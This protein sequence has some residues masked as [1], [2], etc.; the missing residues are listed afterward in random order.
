MKNYCENLMKDHPWKWVRRRSFLPALAALILL[1]ALTATASAEEPQCIQG[2]ADISGREVHNFADSVRR[3]S[4]IRGDFKLTL[5]E[6]VLTG[7]DAVVWISDYGEADENLH[8]ITVYME[9]DRQQPAAVIEPGGIENHDRVML[10]VLD[11]DGA[12]NVPGRESE[13]K[14]EDFPLYKRGVEARKKAAEGVKEPV[15]NEAP[16]LVFAANE[17]GEKSGEEAGG[18]TAETGETTADDATD[19]DE[20]AEPDITPAKT[21]PETSA[22]EI[23]DETA[24][25]PA[26]KG[27]TSVPSTYV[28][29]HADKIT[30]HIEPIPDQKLVPG[31]KERKRRVIVA[32]GN[33]YLSRGDADSDLFLELRSETAVI[34]TEMRKPDEKEEKR[35][36]YSPKFGGGN[37]LGEDK[38][39][40]EKGEVETIVGVYL[41]G[42]VVIA[43][44]ER[45]LRAPEA[46]Y[47]FITDR[48]LVIEPVFRTIQE[49]RNIP[50]YIRAKVGRILSAR[51]MWF[52]DAKVSTSDFYSPSYHIGAKQVYLMD[53]TPYGPDG[54][55]LSKPSWMADMEHTT[56]NIRSVPVLYWPKL[57]DDFTQGNTPLRRVQFGREGDFGWGFETQWH[58][59][60]LMGIPKPEGVNAYLDLDVYEQ[61]VMGGVTVKYARQSRGRQY[62]GYSKLYGV[63]DRRMKDDFG[64][65]RDDIPAPDTRG[66]LLVR[67]KEYL[68]K[69]W[70]LQFEL[71]YIC[72]R[73]FL[74][75]YERDE[76]LAGKEQ[77][78]LIY[79]M[80]QRDNWAFTTLL[81]YKTN[82]FLTQTDSYP[83]LG[84]HWIGEPLWGDRLSFY[85]ESHLGVKNYRPDNDLHED[86]SG[87]FGRADTRQEIELPMQP[88]GERFPLRIIPYAVGRLTYWSDKPEEDGKT[89]RPYGQAG[90]KA[91]MHIWKIYDQVKSRF[92]DINQLKHIITPQLVAWVAGAGGVMPDN[93]YPMD[94]DIEKHLYD[95]SGVSIG[96]NQRLQT[97]RGPVGAEEVVDWMRLNVTLGMFNETYVEYPADGR[98]Y[99]YRPEYS[100]GRSH[101]NAD[102][103]WQISDSTVFMSDMNYDFDN[104]DFGRVDAGFAVS[105]DP[106]LRYYLGVRHITDLNS[107]VGTFGVNYK[108]NEKYSLSFWEQYDMDYEGGQNMG[109]S[110]TLVR[111]FPRWYGA[112]TF[113]YDASNDALTLLLTFWPEGIPEVRIGGARMSLLGG[114]SDN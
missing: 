21:A 5:G 67:H 8:E 47:D 74:E 76:F 41:L 3:V 86:D 36:P 33:V 83:D 109:T 6:R 94:P 106:R 103:T 10:V 34:F 89:F 92:W 22:S 58:L 113:T 69:D 99:T 40:G 97:K 61:G 14:P 52:K 48:A 63:W 95:L 30:G 19:S 2:N 4:I 68:P 85:S 11:V 26:P 38:L 32:T 45:Y 100:V 102:Y 53:Q 7:R 49:Q 110:V 59:F 29:Y 112:F 77:E 82:R 55:R 23:S 73:N 107:T 62:T 27:P 111:K 39:N 37:G 104:N 72:D 35:S 114:S 42:D 15:I 84:F 93:L 9:G 105:R 1:S 17:G 56:F 91:N 108:I 18:E 101:L 24:T 57:K 51:E 46:Y 20:D 12:I 87:A 64:D 75:K 25:R 65:E 70:Q 81:Q 31:Q 79:A 66:R 80:K 16:V 60:R 96:V 43:R 13:G 50:V 54:R 90:V 88:F 71:S 44:G 98:S 78:T 28:S